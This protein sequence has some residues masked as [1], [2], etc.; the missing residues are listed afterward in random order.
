MPRKKSVIKIPKI[1][2]KKRRKKLNIAGK[3]IP[4]SVLGVKF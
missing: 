3:G 1:S 4:L 2:T